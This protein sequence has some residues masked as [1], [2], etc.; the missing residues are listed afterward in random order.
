MA[1]GL[2]ALGVRRGD[3]VG[4]LMPNCPSFVEALFG[5][6][7]LGAV[8]V[9]I[10]ARYRTEEL[11]LVT[12]N[13]SL[14]R[15]P[16]ERPDRGP[17]RFRGAARGRASGPL[18]RRGSAH[19]VAA[20]DAFAAR[21]RPARRDRGARLPRRGRLRAWRRRSARAGDRRCR[22]RGR[23]PRRRDPDVH[24]RH[25]RPP[26]GMPPESRGGR[27][28]GGRDGRALPADERRRVVVPA[29]ALSH[30]RRAAARRHPHRRLPA[31]VH[32]RL[33]AGCR[34]ASARTGT[35][36]LP[37][38]HLPDR[39][40]GADRSPRPR[41]DRPQLGAP[42][43]HPGHD[44]SPRVTP[45]RTP[46]CIPTPRLRSH[47]ARRHPLAHRPG[48][49]G[50]R[51]RP[52]L[53]HPVARECRSA[54]STARAEPMSPPAPAARSS[55]GAGACSRAT[56]PAPGQTTAAV[57]ED[58]WF[59][60]GDW[61]S[62]DELGRISYHGRLKDMLKIGG[63]NVAA[64]ELE[65]FLA[66]H[67][68]VAIVQVVGVPDDHLVEV[69]AAFVEL[70]AGRRAERG[71]ARRVLP[72]CDREL[73]DPALRPL[74]GRVADVGHEDPEGEAARAAPGRARGGPQT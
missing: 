37:L 61:G 58:G 69:A 20:R 73:Q 59:H 55:R 74:R 50:R 36:D 71:R 13:A 11:A 32:D 14:A 15:D 7:L 42:D 28:H 56:S 21:L 64:V 72:R 2:R 26:E 1:Q 45:R 60:T 24:L 63:E 40:P 41:D 48:D 34:A 44:A 51:P 19:T 68:A 30:E 27:P 18:R 70:V 47:R 31:R 35:S 29:A 43:Q 5:A 10:N 57:D 65:S 52:D 8:P 66:S 49:A 17:G 3:R 46:E 16:H 6:S 12:A 4:I 53:G 25:E 9:L 23:D 67:P 54:S 22:R 33:R 38:R 39:Q 62:I